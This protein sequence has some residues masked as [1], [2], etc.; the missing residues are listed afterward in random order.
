MFYI[1]KYKK[2]IPGLVKY[3]HDTKRNVN[4][5]FLVTDGEH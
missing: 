1:C 3:W 5:K 4:A 2:C